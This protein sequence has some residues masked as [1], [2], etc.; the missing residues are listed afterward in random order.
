ME[1]ARL[2]CK[3]QTVALVAQQSALAHL[4]GLYHESRHDATGVP[5]GPRQAAKAERSSRG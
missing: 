1:P 2:S 3:L 5:F 4:C